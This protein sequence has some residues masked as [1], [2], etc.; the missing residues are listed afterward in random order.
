MLKNQRDRLISWSFCHIYGQTSTKQTHDLKDE[1][2]DFY[3]GEEESQM[4]QHKPYGQLYI[5][6]FL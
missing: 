1:E 2:D 3:E 5:T 4:P 6:F